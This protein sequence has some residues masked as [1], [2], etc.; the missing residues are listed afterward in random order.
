[1]PNPAKPC[2]PG[3][4]DGQVE[5]KQTAV[6]RAG[7]V[8]RGLRNTRYLWRSRLN[9]SSAVILAAWPL[10]AALRRSTPRSSVPSIAQDVT[11][12]RLAAPAA[13]RGRAAPS[14]ASP[15]LCRRRRCRVGACRFLTGAGSGLGISGFSCAKYCTA[16]TPFFGCVD[17]R[18]SLLSAAFWPPPLLNDHPT[19]SVGLLASLAHFPRNGGSS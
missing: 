12:P 4:T 3:R 11:P 1:V 8:Q 2:R 16:T 7:F 18:S 15:G 5:E 14:R 19:P 9:G 10:A 17:G 13:R 6:D